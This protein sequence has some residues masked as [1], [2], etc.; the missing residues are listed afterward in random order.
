MIVSEGRAEAKRRN[1][2]GRAPLR[3]K[4]R[5]DEDRRKNGGRYGVERHGNRKAVHH[6]VIL[7][8]AGF[9]LTVK[10]PNCRHG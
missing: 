4:Q 8:A 1:T 6:R 5:H 2:E 10:K 3:G 7:H 9:V